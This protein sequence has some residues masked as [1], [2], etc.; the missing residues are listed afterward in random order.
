MALSPGMNSRQRKVVYM[1]SAIFDAGGPRTDS[2]YSALRQHELHQ[3]VAPAVAGSSPPKA[4]NFEFPCPADVL[5][6]QNAGHAGAVLPV[7]PVV[8]AA[9]QVRRASP[10][11]QT[12][13]AQ[14]APS[15]GGKPLLRSP[16]QGLADHNGRT[17][18]Q[19]LARIATK[20]RDAIPQEFWATSINL[21]WHDPRNERCR[22]IGDRCN[23]PSAQDLKLRHLSSEVLGNVRRTEVSTSSPRKEILAH[24]TNLMAMDSSLYHGSGNAEEGRL[25]RLGHRCASE[26]FHANLSHVNINAV[27]TQSKNHSQPCTTGS[28]VT[29]PRFTTSRTLVAKEKDANEERRRHEKNFSDL[30]DTKMGQRR[31]GQ[32]EEITATHNCNL[33]DTKVEIA[34]RNQ[35]GWRSISEDAAQRKIMENRSDILMFD[36]PRPTPLVIEGAQSH[37]DL[38]MK[39]EDRIFRDTRDWNQAGAEVS[40]R[41]HLKDAR[42]F[43]EHNENSHHLMKQDELASAR[44]TDRLCMAT[45]PTPARKRG[46]F[47]P[48]VG[49][50]SPMNSPRQVEVVRPLTARDTKL[51]ALQSSIFS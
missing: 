29:S 7:A 15:R 13:V 14:S 20:D 26:R 38:R 27:A 21:Q 34:S 42:D 22:R 5:C 41:Q 37:A 8:P 43:G 36:R 35:E 47:S 24:T 2:I 44:M 3:H 39:C 1:H 31:V 10:D 18:K 50:R 51:A 46:C 33:F 48:R 6:T 49:L 9:S 28:P 25:Q 19:P 40:R 4:P 45:A 11:P 16:R 30:F 17:C 12:V 23:S 32:R